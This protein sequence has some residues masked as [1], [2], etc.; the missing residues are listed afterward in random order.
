MC[1]MCR[2]SIENATH[3]FMECAYIAEVRTTLIEINAATMMI[4]QAFNQG[5]YT[6]TILMGGS[7]QL[8][9]LQ[10]TLCFVIWREKC[11]RIFRQQS[12]NQQKLAMEVMQEF[13]SWVT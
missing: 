8:N 9:K 5:H 2:S 1:Y 10:I 12:K 6:D 13:R 11:A 3:L 4:T 7:K